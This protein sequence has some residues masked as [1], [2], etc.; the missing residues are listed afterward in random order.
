M[1]FQSGAVSQRLAAILACACIALVAPAL[2]A[3]R[4]ERCRASVKEH[5]SPP[6]IPSLYDCV[7]DIDGGPYNASVAQE[8]LDSILAS[9]Y[10]KSGHIEKQEGNSTVFI[11]FVLTAPALR[12]TR[13]EYRGIDAALRGRLAAWL[14]KTGDPLQVGDTYTARRDSR[15]GQILYM[16][17]WDLGREVGITLDPTLDYRKGTAELSYTVTPGP[18][19][20][21]IRGLAPFRARCAVPVSSFSMTDIDDFAPANVVDRLTKTH[22]WGCFNAI[23]LAQDERNLEQSGLFKSVRYEVTKHGDG[24]EVQWHVR[25]KKLRVADIRIVG[26]GRFAG[27]TF[28]VPSGLRLE[29]GGTYRQS[30]ARADLETLQRRVQAPNETVLV[31]EADAP[32]NGDELRVTFNVLAYENDTVTIDGKKFRRQA[33]IPVNANWGTLESRN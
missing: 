6:P 5:G 7:Y 28:P 21:E 24:K 8:C 20:T 18:A 26:Y 11:D 22:A 23:T 32:S 31:F 19:M 17:F 3:S 29:A 30:T 1:R 25:G 15:T 4:Q 13:V 16:F 10:F 27:H 33:Q 9:G 12:V 14:G 2:F